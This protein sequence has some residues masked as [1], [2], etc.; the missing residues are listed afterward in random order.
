VRAVLYTIAIVVLVLYAP[1]E[2]HV[3]IYQGF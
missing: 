3:F 1:T 2:E